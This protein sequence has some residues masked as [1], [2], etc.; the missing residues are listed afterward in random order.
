M[1]P[2]IDYELFGLALVDAAQRVSEKEIRPKEQMRELVKLAEDQLKINDETYVAWHI[3]EMGTRVLTML[4][5]RYFDG[6]EW[7]TDAD[8]CND[9]LRS[10]DNSELAPAILVHKVLNGIESFDS[11]GKIKAAATQLLEHCPDTGPKPNRPFQDDIP[12]D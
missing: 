7:S 6:R 5:P 1:I 10:R 12:W 11:N 4:Y 8:E 2:H 3:S 9:H